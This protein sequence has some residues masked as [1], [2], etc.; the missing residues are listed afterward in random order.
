M[1][2]GKL[3]VFVVLSA[4]VLSLIACGGGGGGGSS[5]GSAGDVT[6]VNRLS[7][8]I[9]FV[10]MS[11][12]SQSNWGEDWLGSTEV[13]NGGASRSFTVPTNQ[14]SY[15][16]RLSACP[17]GERTLLQRMGVPVDQGPVTITAE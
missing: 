2:T 16:I 12:S 8:P 1:K 17:S 10:Q 15:D 14:G 5:G 6:I 11:P 3:I 9:C 7:E 4:L 13:I